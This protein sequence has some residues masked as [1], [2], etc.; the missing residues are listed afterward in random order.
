MTGV[1]EKIEVLYTGELEDMSASIR[2]LADRSDSEMRKHMK[3]MGKKGVVGRVDV[4]YRI[5]GHPLDE[6]TAVV[7]VYIT[8]P[9]AMGVGDKGVFASQMKTVVG[10]VL[11]G[12]CETEDGVPL[13]AIFGYYGLQK[14]IV[15]SADIMGTANTVLKRVGELAVS[16]Y[17]GQ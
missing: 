13:D 14:R 6:N 10:S 16:A 5:D 17:K 15:L 12:V 9:V 11:T 4:G 7:R 3:Q 8:G 1:V 2:N